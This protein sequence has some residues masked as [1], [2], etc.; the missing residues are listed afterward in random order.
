M[1]IKIRGGVYNSR[2]FKA[3]LRKN[4]FFDQKNG[5]NIQRN[6]VIFF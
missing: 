2:K 3:N 6:S 1:R 4:I 5:G